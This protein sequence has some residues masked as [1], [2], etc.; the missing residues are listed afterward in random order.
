MSCPPKTSVYLYTKEFFDEAEASLLHQAN[1]SKSAAVQES[2]FNQREI[3][4]DALVQGVSLHNFLGKGSYG[5]AYKCTFDGNDYVIKLP[6]WFITRFFQG[7]VSSL[8]GEP[9]SNIMAKISK[10]LTE[11][12]PERLRASEGLLSFSDQ[13]TPLQECV[14]AFQLE[15]LNAEAILEPPIYLYRNE[16]DSENDVSFNPHFD[17]VGKRLHTISGSRLDK[18]MKDMNAIRQHRGHAH[19]HPI[20]HMDFEIPCILSTAAD[21]C[22]I[23]LRE[24]LLNTFDESIFF[25]DNLS[26]LWLQTAQQMGSA[27]QYMQSHCTIYHADIKPDN[28]FYKQRWIN[29]KKYFHLWLGDFGLCCKKGILDER[30]NCIVGTSV[31]N[32]VDQERWYREKIP[33]F[34]L[35]IFQYMMTLIVC[36]AV[37]VRGQEYYLV[38]PELYPWPRES[39]Y[40]PEKYFQ[41]AMLLFHLQDTVHK[42]AWSAYLKLFFDV[43]PRNLQKNFDAF[44]QTL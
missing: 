21:G 8:E 29:D 1:I 7:Q 26:P 18:L 33:A 38:C 24:H 16:M 31:F 28:I 12:G 11:N 37:Q 42:N 35:T 41:L 4:K 32:P 19:L 44:M 22:L 15:G 9:L 2:V 5:A 13:L 17:H 30:N 23:Q 20:L 34:H 6:V 14:F 25:R 36:I 10:Q 40:N 3:S 39:I 27:L 43:N